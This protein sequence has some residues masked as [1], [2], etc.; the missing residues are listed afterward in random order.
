MAINAG[1]DME[2]GDAIAKYGMAAYD[3]SLIE[4]AA[5]ER[6]VKA[7]LRR[8]FRLGL[9]DPAEDDPWGLLGQSVIANDTHHDLARE[10]AEKSIVLLKNANASGAA[11]LPLEL[12]SMSS[13]VVSGP[14]ADV[15]KFGG[16]SGWPARPAISPKQGIETWANMNGMSFTYV[17]FTNDS[18]NAAEVTAAAAAD[19]SIVV[20][21]L[22]AETEEEGRDRLRYDLPPYQLDYLNAVLAANPRSIVLV[23]GG[24][25]IGLESWIDDA[26]AVLM[27][28]YPGE[29][30]GTAIANILSGAVSP[31]GRLPMT[32]YRSLDQLPRFDDY[33]MS[34]NRTYMFLDG[35]P[36]YPFGYGLSY[37]NFT[38]AGIG[39]NV[40]TASD[41][42]VVLVGLDVTNTG[43]VD[44]DEVVQI[45]VNKTGS[46]YEKRAHLQLKGFARLS[47]VH[48]TTEHVAIPI[49]ASDL[50]IWNPATGAWVLEPGTYTIMAGASAKDIRLVTPLTI[51]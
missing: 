23:N 5:L 48:G 17:P 40:S 24:S 19:V 28:W 46:V 20:C 35:D 44:A 14:G 8:W 43:T 2:C 51:S 1:L 47:V 38:Y 32:F 39:T 25:A 21:G 9:F 49:K 11:V 27:I 15:A 6:A 33:D 50:K 4:P 16:Y 18:N 13:I 30:G 36:L 42:D 12:A 41:G 26:A 31:S 3:L 10:L 34:K 22:G 37:T 29:D 7:N 45:Y